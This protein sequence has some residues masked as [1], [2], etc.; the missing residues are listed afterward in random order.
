[1]ARSVLFARASA[2]AV[3]V[4]LLT[5]SFAAVVLGLSVPAMARAAFHLFYI[6]EA[7]S[8]ADGS[9]QFIELFTPFD[10]QQ[11]LTISGGITSNEHSYT[12]ATNS[13]APS[14]GHAVLLATAGF[15]SLPGGATPDYV[16]PNNFFNPAGDTIDFAGGTD[17]QTFISMPTD[18]IHSLN[19]AGQFQP[20][21]VDVNSPRNYAGQGGSLSAGP[22]TVAGDY[23]GNG[24]VDMADYV[25]WRNGG[26]LQNEV[27]STGT[28]DAADYGAWRARFGNTSGAESSLS[29]GSNVPEPMALGVIIGA[30]AWAGFQ[31]RK[32]N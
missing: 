2:C 22:P 15:A 12:F 28:V 31:R 8:N 19:F 7:Y 30:M 9:V 13:P 25:L 20:S 23:N 11:F 10:S 17:T 18:G 27:N 3:S 24:V 16:I 14:G 5:I 1:M 32:R 29:A 6:Q 26:P 21:V 4:R